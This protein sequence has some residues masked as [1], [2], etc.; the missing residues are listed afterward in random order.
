MIVAVAAA[1]RDA[2]LVSWFADVGRERGVG[3]DLADESVTGKVGAGCRDM[4]V[5]QHRRG[6]VF[7][8]AW[9]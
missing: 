9:T 6:L 3:E 7:A 8:R 5:D 1:A 4:S 2:A